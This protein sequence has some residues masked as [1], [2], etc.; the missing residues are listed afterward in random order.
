MLRHKPASSS[1][2]LILLVG[3]LTSCDPGD[4]EHTVQVR[5]GIVSIQVQRSRTLSPCSELPRIR[6]RVRQ[7]GWLHPC[8]YCKTSVRQ[9]A[10]RIVDITAPFARPVKRLSW[11]G[12]YHVL[13]DEF[14]FTDILLEAAQP[15]LST[16]NT[17]FSRTCLTYPE[18]SHNVHR[19]GDVK[20]SRLRVGFPTFSVKQASPCTWYGALRETSKVLADV[21]P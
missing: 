18:S 6:S 21:V 7:L 17:P 12:W 5:L 4:I 19:V 13:R 14:H 11:V 2:E 10:V 15:P 9:H 3:S 16:S 8:V 20:A 1:R